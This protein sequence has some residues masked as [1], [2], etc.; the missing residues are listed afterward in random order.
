MSKTQIVSGGITDGTIATADIADDAV[1]AAK[2]TGFGKIL[3]MKSVQGTSNVDINSESFAD[4]TSMAITFSPVSASSIILFQI[5]AS[6]NGDHGDVN[7]G[8]RYALR[9][10]T[11]GSNEAEITVFRY[12]SAQADY[13]YNHPTVM[14]RKASW[15]AG[16]SKAWKWQGSTT[17]GSNLIK[18]NR[19]S[20]FS[21]SGRATFSITEYLE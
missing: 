11:G 19:Q 13:I 12:V 7:Q 9:D 17:S 3:Q 14:V 16:T 8:F 20:V 21:T 2:A 5:S 18:W 4:L 6:V 15:G 10:N 1:T